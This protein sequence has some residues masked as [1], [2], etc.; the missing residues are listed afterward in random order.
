MENKLKQKNNIMEKKSIEKKI[1]NVRKKNQQ[2]ILAAAEEDFLR[3]G[4]QGASIKR[5][6]ESAGIPRAN[7]HYYYKNK[8]ELYC[9]ILNDI[10]GMWNSSFDDITVDDDPRKVLSSYIRAKVMFSKN[11]P[12]RSRIFASEIIHGAPHLKHYLKTT[13][14]KWVDHKVN[15]I[16]AWVDAGKID[17][18][19]PLNLL[20]FIW[21]STQH[22]ADFSAQVC[23]ASGK[24]KLSKQDFDVVA[25]DLVSLILK[26]IGL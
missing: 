13:N 7:V 2:I 22:Y 25:D 4:F 15:V 24:R 26:G 21:G 23:I 1:G 11:N 6:A 16:Q 14:K 9:E 19:T 10:I 8:T 12:V 17:P 18:I 3:N 5:I 20:F